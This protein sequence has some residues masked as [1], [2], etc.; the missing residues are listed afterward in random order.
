MRT[1]VFL[2]L[3]SNFGL[4]CI[5]L[6]ADISLD[7]FNSSS[8]LVEVHRHVHLGGGQSSGN[9]DNETYATENP[10]KGH[11]HHHHHHMP[12]T[13]EHKHET[14]GFQNTEPEITDFFNA[15]TKGATYDEAREKEHDLHHEAHSS[16]AHHM[17][18]ADNLDHAKLSRVQMDGGRPDHSMD[19]THDGH[20]THPDHSMHTMDDHGNH[21]DHDHHMK[22]DSNDT[23]M[24]HMMMMMY[25][26]TGVDEVVLFKQWSIT[27]VGGLLGSMVGIFLLAV[28]YEGLKYLREHLFKRYVSSIQF[29]TVAVTGESGRVTQVHK[30]ERHHMMSWPHAVQTLLH[31]VQIVLSYFLM[32]IFMTYNV[33]LCLAV[34][35]GAGVGY[36]IFGWKKAT[37]VDI[38]EHCH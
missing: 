26:H 5:S 4:L 20:V 18:R 33:W 37:V 8:D 24:H 9:H 38:T 36:F 22:K 12:T 3:F 30:V 21:G 15:A 31:I 2:I 11:T 6:A 14:T 7:N 10:H 17:P 27:T 35:L 23:G 1:S 16:H 28:I 32:L 13:P 34:V 19:M 25:F 29:S